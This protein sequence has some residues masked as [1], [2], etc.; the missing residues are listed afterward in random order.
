MTLAPKDGH[1]YGFD[2]ADNKLLYRTPVTRIENVQEPFAVDKDVHF[3]PGAAGGGEWNSP[4]YDPMTNFIFTGQND[5]CT[6]VRLQT[7][8]EVLASPVGQIWTGEKSLNPADIFGK[9]TRADGVWAGWL[10]GVDADTG[11][12]KWRLKSNYPIIGAVT[13]T[14]GGVVFFGDMGGNFYALDAAT[15]QKLWGKKI[16]GAIGGGVITY[17]ANGAQK[18]AVATGYVSPAFPVEIRRAKVAILGV[19]GN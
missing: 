8:E 18:V 2:L 11:V 9:F 1:L 19:E 5:W 15:G 16:G 13:P 3:C 12:W 10:H 17:T 6:T 7:R 4:A 14:A